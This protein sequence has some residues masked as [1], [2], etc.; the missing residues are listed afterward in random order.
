MKA[1]LEKEF[2]DPIKKIRVQLVHWKGVTWSIFCNDRFEEGQFENKVHCKICGPDV[3]VPKVIEFRNH[4]LCSS[5]LTRLI[6]ALQAAT[7]ADCG[8]DREDVNKIKKQLEKKENP[9]I[10][11]WRFRR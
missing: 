3:Y 2:I 6:E 4:Y 8:K 1:V 7:L 11:N 5:C 9:T 10:D